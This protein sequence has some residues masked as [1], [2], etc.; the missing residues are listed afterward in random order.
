MEE[1]EKMS[2]YCPN[3]GGREPRGAPELPKYNRS[4]KK[5]RLD[6]YKC[7]VCEKTYL[8]HVLEGG[9]R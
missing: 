3:C 4:S 9:R 7:S 6:V 1:E 5:I 8:I 2:Y